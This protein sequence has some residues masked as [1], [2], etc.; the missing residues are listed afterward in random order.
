MKISQHHEDIRLVPE[1]G[2]ADKDPEYSPIYALPTEEAEIE[3]K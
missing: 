2:W 1:N 3:D